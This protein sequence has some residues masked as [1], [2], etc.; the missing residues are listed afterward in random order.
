MTS[1]GNKITNLRLHETRAPGEYLAQSY[2]LLR[3]NRGDAHVADTLSA[4]RDATQ[5]AARSCRA[6][7]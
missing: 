6:P 3:R 1:T 5:A 7:R 2:L 4:R